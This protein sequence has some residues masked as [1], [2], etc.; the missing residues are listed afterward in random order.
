MNRS[1]MDILVVSNLYPNQRDPR[2]G[3]FVHKQVK[4]LIERGHS[5]V[6]VVPIPWC[7]DVPGLPEPWRQFSGHPSSDT[8]DNVEVFYHRHLALPGDVT[9]AITSYSLR[10]TIRRFVS[11]YVNVDPH[12][13]NA[14]VAIPSG[15]GARAV[16]DAF[17]VPLVTTV[18]GA[19]IHTYVDLPLCQR[20]FR[21]TLQDSAH[22]VLNSDVLERKLN[23][24]FHVPS[25]TTVVPNGISVE[26]MDAGRHT[27]PPPEVDDDRRTVISVGNLKPTKGHR[28]V[29]RALAE[30]DLNDTQYIVVGD[31]PERQKLEALAEELDLARC[32]SFVGQIP[33]E[34][35]PQY[36]WHAD[37]FV[38]PSYREAF[39]IAYL[40]AMTCELPVI[41]CE[42]EGPEMF[43][44]HGETGLLVPPQSVAQLES[45]L[46]DLLESS[47]QR[48]LLGEA[49]RKAVSEKFSWTANAER[50]ENVFKS[51]VET[52]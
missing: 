15:Y 7:P 1:D 48:A 17:E 29:L 51:V 43:I 39:G 8:L 10:A 13:V 24:R 4:H 11:R 32:V 18:H 37:V 25:P 46:L 35:V 21:S 44:D 5:V 28:Y 30:L 38:L 26:E 47:E 19:D 9:K 3:I 33:H 14:H 49:A 27:D 36:L 42:G 6:V 31:G 34:Q 22:V 41:A 23:E 12:V 50:I 16:A 40:E 20:Q 2:R 52:A 45:H